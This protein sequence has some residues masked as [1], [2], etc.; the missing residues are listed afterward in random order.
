MDSTT[1]TGRSPEGLL[2]EA[3]QSG[4]TRS[5]VEKAKHL[6][7]T[8]VEKAV[9]DE[10]KK[11]E[12]QRKELTLRA[13]VT[14]R[15]TVPGTE[16]N[17]Q[18]RT[19][20][21][22]ATLG[23]KLMSE[24]RQKERLAK[25][26][27]KAAE[28]AGVYNGTTYLGAGR[29][30]LV[31]GP[32]KGQI[33]SEQVFEYAMYRISD[34]APEYGGGRSQ[35]QL[36]KAWIETLPQELEQEYVLY[37]IDRNDGRGVK[38]EFAPHPRLTKQQVEKVKFQ[39]DSKSRKPDKYE[40]VCLYIP[41]T[42]PE[43]SSD[44]TISSLGT[45]YMSENDFETR[46][47]VLTDLAARKCDCWDSQTRTLT[48]SYELVSGPKKGTVMT[49]KVYEIEYTNVEQSQFNKLQ[50]WINTL[51]NELGQEVIVY[52]AKTKNDIVARNFIVHNTS[53]TTDQQDVSRKNLTT[54]QQLTATVRI[55]VPS[56]GPGMVGGRAIRGLMPMPDKMVE[57][58]RNKIRKEIASKLKK[59]TCTEYDTTEWRRGRQA[60]G[61]DRNIIYRQ[62]NVEYVVVGIDMTIPEGPIR[63]HEKKK[64][65]LDQI[66]LW[67]AELPKELGQDHIIYFVDK[68]D[69]RGQR[70]AVAM[71]PDA[72]A[73]Q[74]DA[75]GMHPHTGLYLQTFVTVE[76]YVPSTESSE[77]LTAD[78]EP[79]LGIR[80][81]TPAQHQMRKEKIQNDIAKFGI[82]NGTSHKRVGRYR[83]TDGPLRGQVVEEDVFRLNMY[84][85]EKVNQACTCCGVQ[86]NAKSQLEKLL[87]YIKNLPVVL[88]QEVVYY[89][90]DGKG[91]IVRH[92]RLE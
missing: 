31:D 13:G 28:V 81:M 59:F 46:F 87:T 9:S 64:S 18:V 43:Y 26:Q 34:K 16:A 65:E 36:L 83:F 24:E 33:M 85:V 44:Q 11:L 4:K 39:Q 21:D 14:V 67:I 58:T 80:P 50:K 38:S 20:E 53:L 40:T 52:T 62:K 29:Y 84:K 47:K 27:R 86:S 51:P 60:N 49:R 48:D 25:L 69:G 15:L 54:D 19:Q 35:L 92:P 61:E 68:N 42:G 5:I 7:E 82:F 17:E 73:E 75:L 8:I 12:A 74:R 66:I 45:K 41:N 22:K 78:G 72:S 90:V 3:I 71:H 76:L 56:T 77:M 37:T 10:H 88:Q 6:T 23:V 55:S 1:N 57:E 63:E 79:T 70:R 32:Y 30:R 2:L 89:W 91:E